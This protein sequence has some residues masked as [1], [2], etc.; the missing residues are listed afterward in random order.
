MIVV[1]SYLFIS[2][3]LFNILIICE[4][5]CVNNQL[6]LLLLLIA[7]TIHPNKLSL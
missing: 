7:T 4:Q 1:Y 3:N 5:F 2:Y 6:I